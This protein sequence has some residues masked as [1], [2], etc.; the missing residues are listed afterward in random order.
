[1]KSLR[2]CVPFRVPRLRVGIKITGEKHSVRF[3]VFYFSIQILKIFKKRIESLRIGF[4]LWISI[5]NCEEDVFVTKN[6][7]ANNG[8]VEREVFSDFKWK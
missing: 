4:V 6:Q 8:L 5:Q 2:I 3:K 7:F 1:M